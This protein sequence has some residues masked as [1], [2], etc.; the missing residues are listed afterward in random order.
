MKDAIITRPAQSIKN[1][2]KPTLKPKKEMCKTT[3]MEGVFNGKPYWQNKTSCIKIIESED[4][5][6][7]YE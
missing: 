5:E 3:Y 2:V 6:E 4:C 1:C 7:H